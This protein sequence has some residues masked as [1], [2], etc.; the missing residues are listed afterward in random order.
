MHKALTYVSIL[1]LVISIVAAL[2]KIAFP[3]LSLLLLSAALLLELAEEFMEKRSSSPEP[4]R[5]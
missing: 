3:T 2:A 1:L 4:E 5:P